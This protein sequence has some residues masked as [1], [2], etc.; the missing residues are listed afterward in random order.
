MRLSRGKCNFSGE[1]HAIT[2]N[3]EKGQKERENI[4]IW[5][6]SICARHKQIIIDFQP[7]WPAEYIFQCKAL[8]FG[9]Q[10]LGPFGEAL[11]QGRVA[12]LGA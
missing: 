2:G 11:G 3:A 4:K 1:N 5:Q 6:G 8:G 12:A 10:D 9:K 7:F